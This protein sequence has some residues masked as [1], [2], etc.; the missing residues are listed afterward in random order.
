MLKLSDILGWILNKLNA[1]T[2]VRVPITFNTT[3]CSDAYVAQCY[4]IP[5]LK[6]VF[7]RAR[8]T[9]K[10][11]TDTTAAQDIALGTMPA[12]YAPIGVTCSL[13]LYG[14][15]GTATGSFYPGGATI[16]TNGNIS[17]RQ[18]GKSNPTYWYVSGCWNYE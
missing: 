9:R 16:D 8:F 6:M 18:A 7:M 4:A 2:R 14:A 5:A 10:I 13:S 17:F 3:N 1:F 11:S 12:S 15:W